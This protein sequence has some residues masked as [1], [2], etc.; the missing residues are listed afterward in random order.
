M[1]DAGRRRAPPRPR[2]EGAV[3]LPQ[4]V[5]LGD[6]RR[7]GPRRRRRACAAAARATRRLPSSVVRR[8]VKRPCSGSSRPRL[9]RNS[10]QRA[11]NSATS[12]SRPGYSPSRFSRTT[13]RSIGA[14][15]PA[16][17]AGRAGSC[18]AQ[19]GVGVQAPAQEAEHRVARSGGGAEQDGVG[20]G[21]RRP[22]PPRAG[23]RRPVDRRLS[24]ERAFERASGRR[25]ASTS[26]VASTTSGPMPSPPSRTIV[27]ARSAVMAMG[28]SRSLYGQGRSA[29]ARRRG[30]GGPARVR[31]RPAPHCAPR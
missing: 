4:D 30:A 31:S 17:R 19:V 8:R 26:A 15:R 12:P 2:A 9:S 27:G 29:H 1:L 25:A 10:G 14:R 13:S 21:G 22:A 18:R 24:V 11:R 16:A 20:R 23:R 7:R 3:G 6:H 28:R 5:R